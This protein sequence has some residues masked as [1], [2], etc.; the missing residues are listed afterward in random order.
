MAR[1]E[2]I[3]ALFDL[4]WRTRDAQSMDAL[5]G[6]LSVSRAT[7]RRLIT[8]LR[9][10]RGLDV[11]YDREQNGYRLHRGPKDGA[12][13]MLLG[14][15][16]GEVTALLETDVILQQIP[17]GLVRRRNPVAKPVAPRLRRCVADGTGQER[18][19]LHLSHLRQHDVQVF[20]AVLTALRS[21]KRLQLVYH[22]RS[23][24]VTGARQCSPLRLTFYRNNWYLAAWCHL[25]DALRVFSL[26]RVAKAKLMREPAFE[27]PAQ[28]WVPDLDS[29]YGI[30]AG[31]A[32]QLARLQFTPLAARWVAGEQWHPQARRQ[33]LPDGALVLEVPY[34]H[35]TELV[36]EILRHGAECQ[37]LEPPALRR[38]VALQLRRAVDQY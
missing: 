23:T 31:P 10:Q 38:A 26:D 9:D 22:S 35:D 11:R 4:L 27:P 21:R 30:F 3:Q 20:S 32:S 1:F 33:V 34:G 29:G 37:V 24:D 36:Q 13:A 19:H 5:C 18:V 6:A 8:F 17:P 2:N 25:R 14:A 7:V 28:R 16:G 15:E 12:A